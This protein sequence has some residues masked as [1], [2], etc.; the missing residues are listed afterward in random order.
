M[1]AKRLVEELD[2]RTDAVKK[3]GAD[4]YKLR[5]ENADLEVLKFLCSN[6]TGASRASTKE[7][8]QD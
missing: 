8:V 3:I 1:L 7:T 6:S 4:M 5:V 2:A